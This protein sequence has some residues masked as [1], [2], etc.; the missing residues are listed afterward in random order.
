MSF[1]RENG[2]FASSPKTRHGVAAYIQLS[3]PGLLHLHN[4]VCIHTLLGFS[5][6][7][8]Q[9]RDFRVLCNNEAAS[10]VLEPVPDLALGH[11]AHVA[12]G[13]R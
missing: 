3:A 10:V 4:R 2:F 5:H 9:C 8:P 13:C 7:P 1:D 11:M 12:S 6:P